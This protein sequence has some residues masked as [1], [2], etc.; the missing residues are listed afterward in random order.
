[1]FEP[2]MGI[3]TYMSEVRFKKEKGGYELIESL[4]QR[5]ALDFNKSKDFPTS[6]GYVLPLGT[7]REIYS[8]TYEFTHQANKTSEGQFSADFD[9]NDKFLVVGSL[10]HDEL[11]IEGTK[12]KG[13]HL[14]AW[15]LNDQLKSNQLAKQPLNNPLVILGQILFFSFFTVLIFAI[16]FKYVKQLQT[17]PLLIS[18]LSFIITTAFSNRRWGSNSCYR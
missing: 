11:E 9:M 7:D 1:M 13:P 10:K 18:F 4:V 5:V 16:L 15:A 3:I 14:V 12:K 17:K 8:Q 2:G 6:K